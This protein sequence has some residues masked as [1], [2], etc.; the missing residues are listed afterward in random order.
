MKSDWIAGAVR[1]GFSPEQA[2]YLWMAIPFH[3]LVEEWK[4]TRRD[5]LNETLC[6][7]GAFIGTHAEDLF[8]CPR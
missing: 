1:A 8:T 6:D 4:H 3:P 7:S 2:E 5:M